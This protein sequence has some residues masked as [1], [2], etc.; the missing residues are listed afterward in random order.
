MIDAAAVDWS[1]ID[2]VLLD[3]DGTLLD[4]RFDNWFWQEHIPVL[5]AARHAMQIV[6]ARTLLEGKFRAVSGT[7]DWY[8]IEHWSRDD[9]VAAERPRPTEVAAVLGIREAPCELSGRES[10]VHRGFSQRCALAELLKFG[11][12][13]EFFGSDCASRAEVSAR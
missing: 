1:A 6:A 9:H 12:Q 5:Y 3:M 10:E 13:S 4:L 7:I 2:T 8:C 11:G